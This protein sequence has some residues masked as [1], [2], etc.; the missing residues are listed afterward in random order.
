MKTV[1]KTIQKK[2]KDKKKKKSSQNGKY[3]KVLT[4][5]SPFFLAMTEGLFVEGRLDTRLSLPSALG[6]SEYLLSF[7]RFKS[8]V[9]RP[10]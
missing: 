2:L 8:L 10:S 9:V 1:Y 7:L 4:S 6:F 5:V 3:Q